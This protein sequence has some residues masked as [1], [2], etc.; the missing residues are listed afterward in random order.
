M[1][2]SL[3]LYSGLMLVMLWV[4]CLGCTCAP[5][6]QPVSVARLMAEVR[7]CICETSIHASIETAVM[8][9]SECSGEVL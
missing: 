5:S 1:G 4:V 8:R 9:V 3:D 6:V 2:T 7:G